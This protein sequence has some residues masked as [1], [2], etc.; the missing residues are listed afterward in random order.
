MLWLVEV[1]VMVFG[2]AVGYWLWPVWT[3]RKT[4]YKAMDKLDEEV[5]KR[6]KQKNSAAPQTP[7]SFPPP[8]AEVPVTPLPVSPEEKMSAEE[9]I[10]RFTKK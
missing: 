5:Q 10:S 6:Q 7:P 8:V 9:R 2:F 1:P 3:N 4:F